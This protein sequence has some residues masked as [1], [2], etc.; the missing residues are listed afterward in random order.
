MAIKAVGVLGK[1]R[2]MIHGIS[3]ES[4][5]LFWIQFTVESIGYITRWDGSLLEALGWLG[6]SAHLVEL[7]GSR[8]TSGVHLYPEQGSAPF[9]GRNLTT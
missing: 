6:I 9:A 3:S 4:K 2:L 1:T 5:S 8:N 7:P